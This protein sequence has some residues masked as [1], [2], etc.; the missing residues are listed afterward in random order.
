MNSE[1]LTLNTNKKFVGLGSPD[2]KVD[3]RGKGKKKVAWQANFQSQQ[4][5]VANAKGNTSI[6]LNN[7]LPYITRLNDGWSSQAPKGFVQKALE[8]A[9]KSISRAVKKQ[10]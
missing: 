2:N 4:D 6:F 5:K 9:D 10:L 7:N 3:S 8:A 1:T